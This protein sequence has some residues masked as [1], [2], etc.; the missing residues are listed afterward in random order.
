MATFTIR[1]LDTWVAIDAAAPLNE[2]LS[3]RLADLT[4]GAAVGD[5]GAAVHRIDWAVGDDGRWLL[6]LDGDGYVAADDTAGV[7]AETLIAINR[8]AAASVASTAAPLHAGVF[9]VDGRAVALVG[10]SGAGKST[11]LAAAVQA[12][13]EF[14]AEE[15][16]AVTVAAEVRRY[17]RP[18]GLRANGA[19]A[20]GIEVPGGA[21]GGFGTVYP[22]RPPS[23]RSTA[24]VPL[25][26]IALV[27]RRP[28]PTQI[29]PI[30][31]ADGLRRLT[32]LTI[33]GGDG[34]E[35]FR[36][37]DQLVR[38]V[39]VVEM[40]FEDTRGAADALAL[41]ARAGL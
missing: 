10:R 34:T 7:L 1:V 30:R 15:V 37:L 35:L 31:P 40:A 8:W 11:L 41:R 13:H 3:D 33:G 27:N 17:P 36:R 21:A 25:V 29:C 39:E 23:G 18:I 14:V 5:H 19:A 12:G 38:T 22:W 32:D 28:G 2:V 9:A 4:V 6:S 24:T 26:L 20:I 16:A